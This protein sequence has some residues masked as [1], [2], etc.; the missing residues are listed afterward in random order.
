MTT[1]RGDFELAVDEL[2]VVARYA[3]G[4]AQDVLALFEAASPDD[5]RPRA[6][7]DA[8]WMFVNGAARTRLQRV[9]ALDTHRA[10]KTVDNDTARYAAQDDPPVGHAWIE[11][12]HRRPTPI[13][14]DV[15][16]R[17]PEVPGM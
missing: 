1:A 12:A 14:I 13:L 8:A 9:T 7:I 2:R 16:S 17:Y 4:S 6:A 15:L 10:A 11:Q 3:A 5:L